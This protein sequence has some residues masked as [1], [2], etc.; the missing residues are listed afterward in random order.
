MLL[1]LLFRSKRHIMCRFGRLL[2]CF[3]VPYR[4]KLTLPLHVAASLLVRR[5]FY[6]KYGFTL[7]AAAPLSPKAVLLGNFGAALRLLCCFIVLNQSSLMPLLLLFRPKRHIMCRFG[8]V[9]AFGTLRLLLLILQKGTLG[10]SVRLQA[11]SLTAHCRYRLFA[12]MS[13]CKFFYSSSH[14]V[15]LRKKSAAH[16]SGEVRGFFKLDFV[17]VF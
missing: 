10:S 13:G 16:P 9:C 6:Q 17:A 11:H 4:G 8:R 5:I 12:S 3:L 15:S 14:F 7:S 1:L 2:R